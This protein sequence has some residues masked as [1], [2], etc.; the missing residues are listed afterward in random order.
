VSDFDRTHMFDA[1]FTADLP[2]GKGELFFNQSGIAN[3]ILGGWRVNGVVSKYTGL[4]FTPTASATSLNAAFNTQVANKVKPYAKTLGGIGTTQ[5]WFDTSA[6]APVTT[7]DFGTASRNSLRGPGDA[8]FDLGIART[9]PLTEMFHLELRGEGFNVTNTPN[10][11]VPASN[12]SSTSFG[13]ITSTFGSAADQR[14]LRVSAKL[15][16]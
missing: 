6:F 16:F 5:T 11:A 9:F 8:D 1:G 14:I 12:V 10:F 15:N 2:F 7:A 13:H 4:P 3:A